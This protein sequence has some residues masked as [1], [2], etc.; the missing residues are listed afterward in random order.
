MC[1]VGSS[2]LLG[3]QAQLE[4]DVAGWQRGRGETL[5]FLRLAQFTSREA[6]TEPSVSLCAPVPF[7][8]STQSG[9]EPS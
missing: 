1:G 4:H 9:R 6:I 5:V 3:P 8:G 2:F 7:H